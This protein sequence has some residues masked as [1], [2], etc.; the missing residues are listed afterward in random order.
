MSVK[1][2]RWWCDAFKTVTWALMRTP[3]T[4]PGHRFQRGRY[5]AIDLLGQ[6]T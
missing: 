6:L 4:C 2:P 3:Q 1:Q 5:V